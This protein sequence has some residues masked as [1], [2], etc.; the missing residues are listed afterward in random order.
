MSVSQ[1]MLTGAR[2]TFFQDE[3][4]GNFVLDREK[5][6]LLCLELKWFSGKRLSGKAV[7]KSS[8]EL[9]ELESQMWLCII[10]DSLHSSEEVL[11]IAVSKP[12]S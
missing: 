7:I 11:Y 6:I 1:F 3:A 12:S 4:A 2:F 5:V 10:N 9:A 8:D